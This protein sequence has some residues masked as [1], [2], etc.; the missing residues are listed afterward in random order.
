MIRAFFILLT[1]T[2]LLLGY[3]TQKVNLVQ[4]SYEIEKKEKVYHQVIEDQKHLRFKVAYLKSPGRL[5]KMM[6]AAKVDFEL[7]REIRI[8]KV[9]P[10]AIID[11]NVLPPE[12]ITN[13]YGG[14]LN[15]IKEA[16]AKTTKD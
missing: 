13:N 15:W 16:Q 5:E 9:S 1:I 12:V 3:V 7:P 4:L 8:V 6:I 11:A 14:W 10:Q 2:M